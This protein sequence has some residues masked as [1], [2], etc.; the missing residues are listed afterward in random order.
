M[1]ILFFGQIAQPWWPSNPQYVPNIKKTIQT[2]TNEKGKNQPCT[3]DAEAYVGFLE[4]HILPS[5]LQIFPGTPCLFQQDNAR[6]HSARVTI[7]WFCRH[8]VCVLDWLACSPDL[9]PIENIWRIMK[10]R[11]R[12]QRRQ[13]VKQLV[14]Y[15]PIMGKNSTCKTPIIDIFSSQTITKCNQ[16]KR[17]HY[18]V[19]NMPLSQ[20][21]LSVL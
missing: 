6:P 7:V 16:K 19:V 20:P 2:V 3:I 18:L 21:F 8:R 5:R 12:Q 14:L 9:S 17:R 10:G 1:E 13:T 15:T 11:I 4:R